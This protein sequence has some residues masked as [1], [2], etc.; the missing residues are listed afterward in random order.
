V[1]EPKLEARVSCNSLASDLEGTRDNLAFRENVV[2]N[3]KRLAD[4]SVGIL[5]GL[6]F[7][8][9]GA[10]LFL[11]GLGLSKTLAYYGPIGYGGNLPMWGGIFS[12][13]FGLAA[14]SGI[15]VVALRRWEGDDDELAAN[16]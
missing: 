1:R 9:G 4:Y 11:Y 10:L 7:L 3:F 8:V 13:L 14:L 12:M 15:V 2:M 6:G 5:I 16:D